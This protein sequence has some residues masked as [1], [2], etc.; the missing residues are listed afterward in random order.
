MEALNKTEAAL[1]PGTGLLSAPRM[2]L[3][4]LFLAGP[5]Q[6][7]C[8][9]TVVALLSLVTQLIGNSW[10]RCVCTGRNGFWEVVFGRP[11]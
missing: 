10:L 2:S 11:K 3:W 4:E 5:A 1:E 6:N 8:S 9:V 7:Q